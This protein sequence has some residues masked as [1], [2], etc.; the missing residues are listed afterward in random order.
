M[1]KIVV[2]SSAIVCLTGCAAIPMVAA[3]IN[4]ANKKGDQS[5]SLTCKAFP[6]DVFRSVSAANNGL[7]KVDETGRAMSAVY[8][9]NNVKVSLL[10]V[11]PSQ[12]AKDA[13]TETVSIPQKN[14]QGKKIPPLMTE[15]VVTPAV[16]AVDGS[17]QIYGASS[18]GVSRTW[19]LDD[20]I[21]DTT[22]KTVDALVA[23]GCSFVETK[24][25][26]SMVESFLSKGN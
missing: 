16:P 6:D 19:E 13:V 10:T 14:K 26:A 20:G 23:S 15:R 4:G 18:N 2:L 17:Y 1:F 21:G 5:T 11:K 8:D 7:V 22:Q 12:A 3:G 25:G 24:R 9:S